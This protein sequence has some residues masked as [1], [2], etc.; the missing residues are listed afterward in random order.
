MLSLLCPMSPVRLSLL[1]YALFIVFSGAARNTSSSDI[2]ECSANAFD[3]LTGLFDVSSSVAHV[4]SCLS[5]FNYIVFADT[6]G[7]SY[8][9]FFSVQIHLVLYP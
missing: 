4:F 9:V 3:T 2:F 7:T 8:L 6:T 5:A 1:S